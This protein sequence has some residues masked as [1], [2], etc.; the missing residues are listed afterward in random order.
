METKQLCIAVFFLLVF[1]Q[2]VFFTKNR[3]FFGQKRVLTA[4]VHISITVQ[5]LSEK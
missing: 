3:H 1:S 5:L 2:L 4:G